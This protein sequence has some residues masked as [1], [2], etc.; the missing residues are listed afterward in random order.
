MESVVIRGSNRV[1]RAGFYLL[2]AVVPLLLTPWNYELFE[3]NKMMAVYALTVVIVGAWV[4]SMLAKRKITIPKTPLDIPIVLFFLSQLVSTVF[5][6]D[7]HVSWYGYYS[8]FNGGMFSIISYILLYYAFVSH[9]SDEDGVIRFASL[10]RFVRV[11][12]VT[13]TVVA[14]YGIAER[15]GID[16]NLWVQDVQNRVFS[17]LGQPNWL[18]AYLVAL[19]PLPF[20]FAYEVK[21][22]SFK[23]KSYLRSPR[24]V[25]FFALSAIYFLTLLFTRSRSGL[26]GLVTAE[27]VFWGI[28][29]LTGRQP[30]RKNRAL[31]FP[32]A[33]IN[34]AFMLIIFVNGT[35]APAVDRFITFGGLKNEITKLASRSRP[36]LPG[37]PKPAI[38]TPSAYVGP[39]LEVGG[40][41]SSVIRKYVWEGAV[42]AWRS[43]T[44]TMLIGTGTE[45]FAFDFYRFRPIAHNMTSEWDFLYNKAHNEYLNYLATTGIFGL[46]SYLALI[47]TFAW[48]F[49]KRMYRIKEETEDNELFIIRSALMAGWVSILVT[50]FFGF[51]VVIIQVF[52]FL[53]PA[54]VVSLSPET[55]KSWTFALNLPLRVLGGTGALA[56]IVA[57]ALLFIL[58]RFW[59]ADTLYASGYRLD[60]AGSY[61]AARTLL[62]GAVSLNSNEPLYHDELAS[63][64]AGL[65]GVAVESKE[66]TVAATLAQQS[67]KE[68][69]IAVSLSSQN[70]N[71]WKTRTKIF[72][73][74]SAFD[75][76]FN[77]AALQTLEHA[78]VLSP[79]DPKIVYNLAI[80][81]GRAGDN[82]K[83]IDYLKHAIELKTNYRDAYWAL[84]IFY[85]EVKQPALSKQTLQDYLT[86]VDPN[87]KEFQ[88]KIK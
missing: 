72:Y 16:K 69:D 84:S 48:W 18:A 36:S 79:H 20:A 57:L 46:G 14:L 29:L 38:A 85:D 70:V 24:F 66:A 49:L 25:I 73:Q 63:A 78:L 28:S 88:Q 45:T 22:Q 19:A 83:A 8:R 4:V 82:Q 33:F 6:I 65:T 7:P 10:V 31:Q 12:L 67:L 81:S 42:N 87:D 3:Y 13:G 11:M 37:E 5:S 86:K 41:E 50:N 62:T 52:F 56:T 15:L 9:F 54:I 34:V 40:T 35:G 43:S 32:F 23:F 71:F 27:A 21:V 80:L 26:L 47:G 75:P 55:K 51:S 58:M 74:F 1:I 59:Q 61:G 76:Q 17:S 77:Q 44:K 53:F 30:A 60:R 64:L 2:V 39:A 68:S